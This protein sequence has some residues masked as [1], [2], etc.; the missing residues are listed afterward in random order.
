MPSDLQILKDKPLA[1]STGDPTLSLVV[2]SSR[3]PLQTKD[4]SAVLNVELF[5]EEVTQGPILLCIHGV[6]SSAESL[7]IQAIVSDAKASNVRVAVLECEGH[8]YSSGQ[9]GVCPDFDRLVRHACEF[10][11]HVVSFFD[12]KSEE[13]IAF[14]LCGNSMG[15]VLSVY[16]AEEISKNKSASDI[17]YLPFPGRFIGVAP[18]CPAVGVDPTAV[19]GRIIVHILTCLA[20]IA[21][22]AKVPLTPLEDPT[23][24][25]C[26]PDTKRNY[27]G[28]WPLSTSKMLLDVTSNRVPKDLSSNRLSLSGIASVLVI[29]GEADDVVPCES[30]TTFYEKIAPHEKKLRAIPNAG[31][32]LMCDEH[33][34]KIATS[35]I[36]HWMTSSLE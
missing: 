31:H 32:D 35:E 14:A 16:A 33:T 9:Q 22:A 5:N 27:S 28:H 15:G 19:P 2:A 36:F 6:C 17:D 13:E 20:L 34:S 24:Y 26:P 29:T 30:V 8:G 11:S 3:L 1:F 21:P 12:Q 10:V 25:N 4:E 23:H 18:I 7:G